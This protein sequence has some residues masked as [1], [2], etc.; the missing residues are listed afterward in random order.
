MIR[1]SDK[2][3]TTILNNIE[4]PIEYFQKMNNVK[5]AAGMNSADKRL[6]STS[7]SEGQTAAKNEKRVIKGCQ[8]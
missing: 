1:S 6:L 4:D 7:R 2:R 8:K 5:D 3:V